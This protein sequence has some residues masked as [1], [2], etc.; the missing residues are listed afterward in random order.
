M[1]PIERALIRT[2]PWLV[3]GLIASLALLFVPSPKAPLTWF[4]IQLVLL[5][6]YSLVLTFVLM[7][8]GDEV[9]FAGTDWGPWLRSTTSGVALV[10]LVTGTVGL[11][12]LASSAT[13]GLDPSLQYLQLLSALDIA[14]VGAAVM[15]GVYR[16]AS[17]SLAAVAGSIVGVVCVWSIWNYLNIVGFGPG[18]AW[19]GFGPDLI[20]YVI[21]VDVISALI[22]VGVFLFGVRAQAH[23]TEQ[24]SPQS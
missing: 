2:V 17:L 1:P 14:W 18:G 3:A 7:P 6:A 13:L 24:P 16:S 11:V 19:I 10:V 5:V 22:A 15:I 21:P 12:T 8:L 4:S 9:W 23:E 20:R